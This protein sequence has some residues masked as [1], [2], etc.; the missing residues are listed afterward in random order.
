VILLSL[1]NEKFGGL[2]IVSWRVG[3]GKGVVLGELEIE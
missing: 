1:V 3:G 2:P